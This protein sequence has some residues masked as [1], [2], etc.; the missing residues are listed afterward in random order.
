[1]MSRSPS[2]QAVNQV[3]PETRPRSDRPAEG[4]STAVHGPNGTLNDNEDFNNGAATSNMR[5][6]GSEFRIAYTI[7]GDADKRV[8]RKL[9]SIHLF[10]SPIRTLTH[11]Y[12]GSRKSVDCPSANGETDD[13]HQRNLRDWFISEKR[14]NSRAWGAHCSPR[15]F[16]PPR[17]LGLD[18]HAM[19]H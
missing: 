18:S 6:P 11:P 17:L 16:H 4:Q 10:V 9:R 5:T 1:M 3:S 19:H 14:P 2:G 13:H 15:V 12:I 7:R 8:R